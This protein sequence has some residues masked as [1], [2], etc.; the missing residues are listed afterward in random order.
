MSNLSRSLLE[1]P[2]KLKA[3][4]HLVQFYDGE[5]FLIKTVINFIAPALL[6]GEGVILVATES[7]LR[8]LKS[9]LQELQLPPHEFIQRGQ[10]IMMDAE[11]TL[12]QII[13]GNQIDQIKFETV[14]GDLLVEMG[15]RFETVKAYG[16]MVNVLWQ[17]GQHFA[18]LELERLWNGCLENKNVTL[19][20]AYSMDA[21]CEE[22]DGV[23]F[24]DI[25]NCHSHVLPAEGVIESQTSRELMRKIVEL[26]FLNM[27]GAKKM[28]QNQIDLQELT[29]PITSM[30]I[31]LLNLRKSLEFKQSLMKHEI[32]HNLENCQQHLNVLEK[33]L[34]RY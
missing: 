7:H 24:I 28:E 10:L 29:L 20:C 25:C 1:F 9:S 33:M 26:Q 16:E 17:Q 15:S 11:V 23:S 30:K 3:H 19:L 4:D 18:A 32:S 13:S 21:L 27:I 8:I 31:E 5:E 22:R 6:C 12:K 34:E 2:E 14:V